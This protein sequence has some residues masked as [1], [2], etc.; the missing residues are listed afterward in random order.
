SIVSFLAV[1]RQAIMKRSGS[2]ELQ[3]P[4]IRAKLL[5]GFQGKSSLTHFLRVQVKRENGEYVASIVRPTEA[6]YSGWLGSANGIAVIE[7]NGNEVKPDEHVNVF[8]IGDISS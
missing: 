6:Q 2:T 3:Y 1:A 4:M 7:L 8:L 5:G